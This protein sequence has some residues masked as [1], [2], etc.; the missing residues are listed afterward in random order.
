[1]AMQAG[2][3]QLIIV[4]NLIA[5]LTRSKPS[6]DFGALDMLT[7]GTFS[8]HA[9]HLYCDFTSARRSPGLVPKQTAMRRPS[10]NYIGT[11]IAPPSR[12]ELVLYG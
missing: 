5:R 6:V 3:V 8:G 7:C 12:A 4:S 10:R 1:M 11:G 2:R 9:T